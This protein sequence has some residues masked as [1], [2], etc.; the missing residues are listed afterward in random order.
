MPKS[1]KVSF[2]RTRGPNGSNE[3]VNPPDPIQMGEWE[4]FLG[5][6]PQNTRDMTYIRGSVSHR[7]RRSK[8]ISGP[9]NSSVNELEYKGT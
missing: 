2:G 6:Q 9:R 8:R 4:D 1:P 7:N 3:L 5:T